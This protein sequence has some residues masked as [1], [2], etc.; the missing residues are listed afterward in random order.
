MFGTYYFPVLLGRPEPIMLLK[1]PIMLLSNAS[2]IFLSCSNYA[3]GCNIM[4]WYNFKVECSIRV[5]NCIN[6]CSI[7]VSCF[8]GDCSI[9]VYLTAS[10]EIGLLL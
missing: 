8:G 9:R 6:I 2:K 10:K 1:L 3:Q 4:P 7:R 5:F